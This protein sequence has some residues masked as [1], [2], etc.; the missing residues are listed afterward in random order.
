MTAE[1]L[2]VSHR[3]ILDHLPDKI[4]RFSGDPVFAPL[5]VKRK[6]RLDHVTVY[7]FEPNESIRVVELVFDPEVIAPLDEPSGWSAEEV[8]SV[9]LAIK[10]LRSINDYV[11]F[12]VRVEERPV[13]FTRWDELFCGLSRCVSFVYDVCNEVFQLYFHETDLLFTVRC[14]TFGE[15]RKEQGWGPLVKKED[16]WTLQAVEN[17]WSHVRMNEQL[18]VNAGRVQD[19]LRYNPHSAIFHL[20]ATTRIE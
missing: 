17:S 19:S 15:F 7:S 9:V 6:D 2:N 20:A 1:R 18:M 10:Q 14:Q 12:R 11:T 4:H 8:R 16:C 13:W 3:L 5:L